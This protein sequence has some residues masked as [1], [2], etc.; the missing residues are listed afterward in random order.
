MPFLEK[1]KNIIFQRLDE[2]LRNEILKKIELIWPGKPTQALLKNFEQTLEYPHL[3][4]VF[5]LDSTD[6]TD[7]DVAI[8]K[9]LL[10]AKQSNYKAQLSLALTWDR[11][12]IARDHIFTEDKIWEVN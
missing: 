12:D 6:S 8:L 4:S 11:I 1:I 5:R 10:K 7:I 9:A 2:N 3:L